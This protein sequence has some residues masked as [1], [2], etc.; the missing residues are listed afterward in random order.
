M[1]RLEKAIRETATMASRIELWFGE[2]SWIWMKSR[3]SGSV[4]WIMP[5][6]WT[7]L[8]LTVG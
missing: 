1:D 8:A 4:V 7:A 6:C 5:H 2:L 3:P